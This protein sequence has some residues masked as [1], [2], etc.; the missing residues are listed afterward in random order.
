MDPG[1]SAAL[2]AGLASYVGC[3]L[4]VAGVRLRFIA[5]GTILAL[6]AINSAGLR[7]GSRLMQWL[8]ALKLGA[9]GLIA[10][11]AL[12]LRAGSWSHFSPFI[13][14]RAGS[15]PLPVALAAGLVGA[16]FAFGGWWEIPKLA[17]EA[18]EP[19]RTLPRALALGGAI[20]TAIYLIT[21]AVFLYLVPLERVTS[22]ETFTAQAGEALSGPD[23]G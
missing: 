4:G 12:A 19:A 20:I 8:T 9:L 5:S 18:R 15:D 3:A 7:L 23:G 21:S 14:Q 11:L 6:A 10:I 13:T 16:F 22:G 1:I 2:A 17:G